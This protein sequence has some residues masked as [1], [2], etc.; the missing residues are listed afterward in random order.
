VTTEENGD[1]GETDRRDRGENGVI[2]CSQGDGVV[3]VRGTSHCSV[4]MLC[5]Q[6]R[7]A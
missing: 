4:A 1:S 3:G 5:F 6:G 7:H 2:T